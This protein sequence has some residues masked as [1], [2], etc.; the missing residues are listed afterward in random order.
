MGK[1]AFLALFIFLL[2][3]GLALV[4]ADQGAGASSIGVALLAAAGTLLLGTRR[5]KGR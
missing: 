4:L 2:S 3:A 5:Q 1:F